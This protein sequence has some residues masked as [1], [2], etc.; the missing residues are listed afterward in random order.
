MAHNHDWLE[1]LSSL[2]ANGVEYLIVGGV[3]LARHG[4]PRY[5]G[6]L[7]CFVRPSPDNARR[8]LAA[9]RDFGFGSLAID[10]RDLSVPD[11]VVQLGFPPGRIDIIT[12]IE[13]V[14]WDEASRSAVE[15]RYGEVPTRFISRELLIRNKRACGRP[16]D[17]ADAA[18]L[19]SGSE[20]A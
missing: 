7:D 10:E 18:R 2:N 6:D 11:R 19:E 9:L 15:G 20:G 12:E 16:Q 13:G 17:L 14:T 5:T 3:A 4:H 8:V 1:W